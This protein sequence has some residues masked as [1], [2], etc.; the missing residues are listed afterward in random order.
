VTIYE[1]LEQRAQM[2]E[3]KAA[4]CR[5]VLADLRGE[6]TEAARKKLPA[7]LVTAIKTRYHANGNGHGKQKA[8]APKRKTRKASRLRE[9]VLDVLAKAGEPMST[10]ALS[11][12]VKAKGHRGIQGMRTMIETGVLRAHGKGTKRTYALGPKA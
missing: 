12:A 8:A 11:A 9:V 3:R 5:E 2:Y 4:S 7:A 1:K 6:M 10:K